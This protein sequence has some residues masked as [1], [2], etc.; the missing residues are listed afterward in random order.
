MADALRTFVLGRPAR[1]RDG[2]CGQ[3]SRLVVDPGRRALTH[4]V[5]EPRH[6]H[7]QARVVPVELV[8]AAG[9]HV[10][11]SCALA[12]LRDL[13]YAEEVDLE[14]TELWAEMGGLSTAGAAG[15]Y[16]LP[17]PVIVTCE[18]VPEG[19]LELADG[20]R[21]CATDGRAGRVHGV[22]AAADG[23]LAAL[24]V[25]EGRGPWARSVL[26]AAEA[27]ERFDRDAVHLR[28]TRAEVGA[29]PPA[30]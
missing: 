29:A 17:Q 20:A 14:A 23:A 24:V 1:C 22:Q 3:V 6:Q 10:A 27:V 25:R 9:D 28:V 4:V 13:P 21:V 15:A 11:L 18:R 16:D 5:V 19:E 12:H 8:E 30:P 26:V 7:G 2:A